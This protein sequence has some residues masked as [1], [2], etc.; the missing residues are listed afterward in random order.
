[1]Q[2]ASI[3]TQISE[4]FAGLD[5]I[6]EIMSDGDR[7][8]RRTRRARRSPTSRGDVEFDDVSV[9][10]QRRASPVLKHVTFRAPA[11]IDDGARRLERLGQEHA[12]QPRDGVQPAAPGRVLVDGRDLTTLRL[13]DYRAHLGVVLQDNFLFDGTIAEN[14]AYAQARR[15]ARR[16]QAR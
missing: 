14:I 9:R 10:V 3:G 4:A 1:M 8:R 12:H 13:R 11:G 7:G 5:R 16:D 6:R 15:D 2:I